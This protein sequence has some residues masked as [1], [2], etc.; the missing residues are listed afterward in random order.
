MQEQPIM[1]PLI[2]ARL[3]RMG[4]KSGKLM[5][6]SLGLERRCPQ[7]GEFW[8][9]DTEFFHLCGGGANL[10][11]WCKACL[12]EHRRNKRNERRAAHHEHA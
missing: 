8:P 5:I 11:G 10:T 2:T 9:Y 1:S 12:S 4:L 6:T 3:I 7:C